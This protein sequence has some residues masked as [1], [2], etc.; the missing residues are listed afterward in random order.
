MKKSLIFKNLIAVI[1]VSSASFLASCVKDRNDGAVDFSQLT[2]IVQIVEGG[3]AKFGS[4]ALLFDAAD[5]TD[6][7]YFRLNYAATNVA[8]ADITVTLTIDPAALA[9]YN[10]AHPTAT[11]EIFPTAIYSFTQTS[12]VIKAGQ[13]YSD[14]VKLTVRPILVDP[15]KNLMLPITITAVS[16]GTKISGNFGTIY[17]HFIGNCLAGTYNNVG[18]RHNYNGVI[19]WTGGPIPPATA[20]T[21][22]CGTP[23]VFAPVS[24]TVTTTYYANLGA[25]TNRDYFF[26]YDCSSGGTNVDATFTQ[27]FLDGVSNI[28]FVTHSYNSAT[29]VITML[30]TYN[31]QPGGAG[32]DR[33]VSEVMTHQ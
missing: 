6:T 30:S 29:K 32:N 24:S 25:G 3:L 23:K 2:P 4:Q 33:I 31:N 18:T 19:G 14:V 26:T 20:G 5:L 16:G 21:A 17:Y 27:S 8:P 9:T 1:L 22:A 7:A 13:S 12:V 15:S 11:Y 28:L 10:A